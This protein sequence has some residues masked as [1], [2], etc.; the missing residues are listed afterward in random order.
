[1]TTST[2][3]E[4]DRISALRRY[5]ILDTP[6]DG[7]FERV[8]ALA[9]RLFN[10]PIAIVSLVDSDRIWFKS[11]HG[12]DT[13]QIDRDP[14]LCASAILQNDVWIVADARTDPRTLAN[15]L[16]AGEMGLRFYAGAPLRTHDGY[17]LGTLCVIDKEPRQVTP[18]EAATLED[19]ASVVMDEIELRLSAR[20]TVALESA[21][22]NHAEE[23]AS[24]LQEGLLP[25]TLPRIEG[26]EVAAR[27]RAAD[28]AEV[29]GDFYDVVDTGER[30][31]VFLGDACGKGE[32][33]AS[34]TGSARWSLR[35]LALTGLAPSEM[36]DR[37]NR[38]LIDN[39]V[40]TRRYCTVALASIGMVADQAEVDLVLGGHPHPLLVRRDGAIERLGDTCPVVGWRDDV[41]FTSARAELGHGD[42]LFLFSDGLFEALGHGTDS[43]ESLQALLL[44]CRGLPAAQVAE[45]LDGALR[46]AESRDDIAFLIVGRK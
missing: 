2:D 6:P 29:G 31:Y 40:H 36:L 21:L 26:F 27:Y 11:H 5:D 35:A 18:E 33:A 20:Q 23:T 30:T 16:V 46:P 34:L 32:R 37:L 44:E 3:L 8:T 45:F 28:A 19:L 7:S 43:D 38:V 25:A 10:V 42:F 4:G 24:A 41:T 39:S 1:M 13:E 9:A 15:P 14:G 17:N 12:I 22:R